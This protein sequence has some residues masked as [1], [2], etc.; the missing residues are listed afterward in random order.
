MRTALLF[1]GQ[2]SQTAD[3]RELVDEVRPALAERAAQEVGEDPFE[4]VGDGTRFA[5]PALYCAS[6]ALWVRAGSPRGDLIAGHSL[7]ELGALVAAGS[8]SVEDGLWL[9]VQRGRLMQEVADS[10]PPGG[11]LALLGDEEA[12]RRIAAA[13][14]L[15]VANDNAPGQ[16][17]LSGPAEDLDA[18]AEEGR[19]QGLKALPLA[20]SGAFHTDAMSPAVPEFRA[21]LARIEV[22]APGG[23]VFSSVT[24]RPFAD[25]RAELTQALVRPVRWRETLFALRDR[26]ADRFVEVGPGKVLRGLVRRTLPDVEATVLAPREVAHA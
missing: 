25:I 16:L 7:G 23:P 24:A 13:H 8:I 1:P 20:V 26:G 17:I 11:M 10:R 6:V 21:A 22:R 3:M 4:R 9:A 19:E 14:L 2:G 12:T 18:A 5:Q 15:T